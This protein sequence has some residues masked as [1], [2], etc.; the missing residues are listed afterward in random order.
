MFRLQTDQTNPNQSVFRERELETN[1]GVPA[2][3]GYYGNNP[4]TELAQDFVREIDQERKREREQLYHDDLQ[5][6][7]TKYEQQEEDA[8]ER[9]ILADELQRNAILEG[10]ILQQE[11][12]D[13][14]NLRQYNMQWDASTA[15]KEIEKRRLTLPW[16]PAR[17]KRLPISKRSPV[18]QAKRDTEAANVKLA[19][20]LQALFGEPSAEVKDRL[21][22]H[23]MAKKSDRS[24]DPHNHQ[25][26][27][28]ASGEH[29]H[30]SEH[31]HED[32]DHDD[33]SHEHED[34]EGE[35]S[36]E[37]EDDDDRKKKR[38]A[39]TTVEP[40]PNITGVNSNPEELKLDQLITSPGS[41]VPGP[42]GLSG[43]DEVARISKKS[44]QWS[45]YFGLDRKKKSVDDWY[46]PP[47]RWAIHNNTPL[48]FYAY[49]SWIHAYYHFSSH[50][51]IQEAS[52]SEEDDGE[53]RHFSDEITNEKI[54]NIERKLQAIERHII[55]NIMKYTGAHDR[56]WKWEKR[57][58]ENIP[59][60]NANHN[61]TTPRR[62]LRPKRTWSIPKPRHLS[63]SHRIQLG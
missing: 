38:S 7:L 63:L 13:R 22:L 14:N 48:P 54:D 9:E 16:L 29:S 46:M 31:S 45:K 30:E 11:L 34:H 37:E 8:I 27:H 53:D 51:A 2:N 3:V 32:H 20:D 6:I 43:Y 12:K 36:E 23:K 49:N 61:V 42:S 28:H 55:E 35:D 17:R 52:Q 4:R 60:I 10:A 40:K 25:H 39:A 15:E 57:S 24:V 26:Q 21:G 50:P 44:I 47:Y 41:S 1:S 5:R 56:K 59:S 33:H 62:L 19:G 18:T 58:S